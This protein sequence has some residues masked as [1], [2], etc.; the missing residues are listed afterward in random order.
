MS[1][2]SVHRQAVVKPE[3]KEKEKEESVVVFMN[4]EKTYYKLEKNL[5]NS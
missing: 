2:R 3:K 5:R 1:T 4:L